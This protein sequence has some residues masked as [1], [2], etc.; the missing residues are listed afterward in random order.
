MFVAQLRDS[1]DQ[2]KQKGVTV[3][4]IGMGW[5]AAAAAFKEERGIPFPLLVDHRKE[6]YRAMDLKRGSPWE[7]LGPPMWFRH[8]RA[9]MRQ[10]FSLAQQ[11]WQQLAGVVIA[12]PGGEI[13]FSH[14]AL[15][16]A[17]NPS[18]EKLVA[19]LPL[20]HP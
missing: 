20:T 17:D 5:P 3:A 13:V 15:D 9:Y 6:T 7:V 12:E 8:V 1:Y 10:G 16:P 11:D 4:A 19:A 14:R 2:F 18:V